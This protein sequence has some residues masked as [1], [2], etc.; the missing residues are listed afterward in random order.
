MKF[1]GL[2]V[3]AFVE[4]LTTILCVVSGIHLY[5]KL[6]AGI[7]AFKVR[8]QINA[9]KAGRKAADMEAGL[10]HIFSSKPAA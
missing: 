10:R 2:L 8:R 3:I 4:V 5:K 1:L 6:E 9:M 7:P